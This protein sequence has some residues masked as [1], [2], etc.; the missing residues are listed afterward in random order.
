MGLEGKEEEAVEKQ[1]L[2]QPVLLEICLSYVRHLSLFP[3]IVLVR[4]YVLVEPVKQYV[5]SFGNL[6]NNFFKAKRV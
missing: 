2:G 3:L 6:D 5:H 1:V 4:A